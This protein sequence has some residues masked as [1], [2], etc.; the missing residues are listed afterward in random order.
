[1]YS[2]KE[3]SMSN[4][5]ANGIQRKMARLIESAI[6]V[7]TCVVE[8]EDYKGKRIRPTQA[9]VAAQIV[10]CMAPKVQGDQVGGLHLHL[11]VPRPGE[12][13]T[14]NNSAPIKTIEQAQ[15]HEAVTFVDESEYSKTN[16]V[17]N[18]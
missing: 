12:V 18:H 14:L 6:D 4:D 16:K 13:R 3:S 5:S 17:N 15:T 11:N 8:G 10:K 2:D 7:S 1:M 9:N